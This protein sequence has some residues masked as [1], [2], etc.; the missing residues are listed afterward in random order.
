MTPDL[1]GSVLA[2]N[3]RWLESDAAD[4]VELRKRVEEIC[5]RFPARPPWWRPYARR[6]W[7]QIFRAVVEWV[8]E[9]LGDPCLTE[10]YR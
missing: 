2:A 5:S 9:Q 6:Q 8:F 3:R 4:V 10:P 7:D 1:V